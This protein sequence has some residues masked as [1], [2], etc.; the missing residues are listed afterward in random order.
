MYDV[1]VTRL[2]SQ[3][4]GRFPFDFDQRE[5]SP[6]IPPVVAQGM[7]VVPARRRRLKVPGELSQRRQ[8]RVTAALDETAG[9]L[10]YRPTEPNYPDV[11]VVF[12]RGNVEETQVFGITPSRQKLSTAL[13]RKT[14]LNLSGMPPLEPTHHLFDPA[15]IHE[16]VAVG[17]LSQPS[18]FKLVVLTTGD[19]GLSSPE[20]RNRYR[21][22]LAQRLAAEIQ[23]AEPGAETGPSTETNP[24]ED[25]LPE[26][27]WIT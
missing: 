13:R 24:S 1:W 11:G 22:M 8:S 6:D 15:G 20:L 16:T 19:A 2:V 18:D 14:T 25:L 7:L 4:G 12:K 26:I 9:D 27:P 23:P 17:L 3:E 21:A 10:T 5:G